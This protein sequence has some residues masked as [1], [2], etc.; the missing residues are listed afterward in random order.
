VAVVGAIVPFLIQGR[1]QTR[2]LHQETVLAAVS[3]G[4]EP[5]ALASLDGISGAALFGPGEELIG[6]PADVLRSMNERCPDSAL[7]AV[8]L[9][10]VDHGDWEVFGACR[11]LGEQ[12]LVA[13]RTAR[14]WRSSGRSRQVLLLALVFGMLAGGVVGGTVRKLLKPL[15]DISEAARGLANGEPVALIPP[16]EPELRPLAEALLQLYAAMQA[17]D[18]DIELRL[19]LTRQLGAVVA[20]EVRNPLQSIMMLADVVAHE[21]RPAEREKVLHMIQQ[22]LGLI[23]EVVHRLVDSGDELRL[24]RREKRLADLLHR[25]VQLA[26]PTARERRVEIAVVREDPVVA[27]VDAAL[28]RRALENL[29]HNA[30]ALRGDAGGGRVELA[31]DST[32]VD[33]VMTVD[34][35]GEG[36]AVDDRDRI[37]QSGY[38]NREGGTGL[39][40]PLARKVA[41]AHGGTLIVLSSPLGGARFELRIPLHG[42]DA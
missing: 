31:L 41:E 3:V 18:D 29:V 40:L 33:A 38:S 17:R 6:E 24:I 10:W 15:A 26:S 5:R 22:E 37:F 32:P 28:L 9:G 21:D 16:E 23:E 11:K 19:E 4:S 14:S 36:V 2:A 8:P 1:V 25:C 27:E 12:R 35:D 20:H 42:T 13:V 30:V 39:G 7:A 34:D